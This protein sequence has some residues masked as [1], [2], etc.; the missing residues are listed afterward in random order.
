MPSALRR[1]PAGS[2]RPTFW[3]PDEKKRE[4]I[5]R[6]GWVQDVE[7]GLSE[8]PHVVLNQARVH[9]FY[10]DVMRKSPS[11]LE[12]HY[13]RRLIDLEIDERSG[14]NAD[15][16][17]VTARLERLDRRA[18]GTDR[19]GAGA[20]RGGLRRRAQHR[21][22]IDRARA[23]RRFR[24]SRLG[25]DGRAGRHRFSRCPLQD[26]DPVRQRRQHHHHP[27]RRRLSVSPLYRARQARRGRT[28]LR[29][30]HH[31]RRSDRGGAAHSQS[32]Y[33]RREGDSP[34]G[35]STRSASGCATSSTT[36]PKRTSRSACRA[37]SSPAMPATRTARKPGR[38]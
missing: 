31:G 23:R 38:A 3:K 7:D 26:A 15:P 11:R 5:V 14:D 27:A 32:A 19:D 25:R 22:Q 37:C 10:L 6:S 16:Y 21:A 33:A 9:D 35:R 1:K 36:C 20:L 18:R 13:A 24:Q 2:T 29:S 4:H 12:P 8:F 17:Q 30:Q 28:R 34:G